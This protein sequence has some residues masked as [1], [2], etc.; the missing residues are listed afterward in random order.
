MV[1]SSNS[2]R[3][4]AGFSPLSNSRRVSAGFSPPSTR[5]SHTVLRCGGG[6]GGMLMNNT[7]KSRP[8]WDPCLSWGSSKRHTQHPLSSH[9][10]F[11]CRSGWLELPIPCFGETRV[12]WGHSGACLPS[13]GATTGVRR[14]GP[15]EVSVFHPT[16]GDPGRP[17]RPPPPIADVGPQPGVGGAPA[18]G[19]WS[20]VAGGGPESRGRVGSGGP[21]RFSS[22]PAWCLRAHTH[23][24]LGGGG[25]RPT[26]PAG[27]E[28]LPTPGFHL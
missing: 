16:P 4:S 10:R 24:D 21:P 2:R 6:A 27:A 15:P 1:G 23:S 8:S 9:G 5:G 25:W 18:T 12:F 20:T 28:T 26:G 13:S 3:V 17:S 22:R 7:P 19:Q 11:G 14:P